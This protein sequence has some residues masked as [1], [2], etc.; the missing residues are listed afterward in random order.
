ME[1]QTG[2][3]SWTKLQM[4]HEWVLNGR[5]QQIYWESSDVFGSHIPAIVRFVVDGVAKPV[6]VS[7]VLEA[8]DSPAPVLWSSL[9]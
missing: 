6:F 9:L 1:D 8:D 7:V 3:L 4:W 5:K 2:E